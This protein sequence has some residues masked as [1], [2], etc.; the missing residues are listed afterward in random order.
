MR[1]RQWTARRCHRFRP[2]I[3][4]LGP[5]VLLNVDMGMGPVPTLPLDPNAD[6]AA[7]PM[8][9]PV[10]VSL[11]ATALTVR[12]GQTVTNQI[13]GTPSQPGQLLTYTLEPSSPEL[14]SIDTRTGA[15]SWTPVPEQAGTGPNGSRTYRVTVR[16][17]ENSPAAPF[18]IASFTVRVL[19]AVPSNDAAPTDAPT[20]TEA[21][22]QATA[23]VQPTARRTVAVQRRQPVAAHPVRSHRPRLGAPWS[24]RRTPPAGHKTSS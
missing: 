22:A 11:Q 14:S 24:Y 12:A 9:R 20:V 2:S 18:A 6:L 5:R 13:T 8:Y 16:V 19:P 10:G 1:A 3:A 17:T 4:E 21:Q 15:F 7:T 23:S